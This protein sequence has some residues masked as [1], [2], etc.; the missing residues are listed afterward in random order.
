[1]TASSLKRGI[2]LLEI[3]RY[4]TPCF[5]DI[6][7]AAAGK[8]EANPRMLT[9]LSTTMRFQQELGDRG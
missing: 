5:L 9:I 7:L 3:I 6:A 1:M 8:A 4:E 2:A